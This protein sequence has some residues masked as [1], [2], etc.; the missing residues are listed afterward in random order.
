MLEAKP[1]RRNCFDSMLKECDTCGI[2]IGYGFIERSTHKVGDWEICS[3]CL[4]KLTKYGYLQL[5][6]T[7][8]L[9]VDG[10]IIK[11]LATKFDLAKVA[12]E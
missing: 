11:H 5:T 9:L 3:W 4:S 7:S 1:V 2:C 12:K 10:S 6:H 8:R